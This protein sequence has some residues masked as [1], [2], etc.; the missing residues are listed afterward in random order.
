M[1]EAFRK[2][3]DNSGSK[4]NL[5]IAGS[6]DYKYYDRQILNKIDDLSLEDNVVLLGSVSKEELRY[7][8]S[9]CELLIFPSPFENFAY[10]LVEAMKCGAPIVCSNTTAMPETCNNAALYF[11]PYDI[12]DMAM[13]M[14]KVLQ[15]EALRI[16]MIK[17]SLARANELPDYGEV[18]I[19]TLKIIESQNN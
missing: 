3:I 10:T 5:L 18:T 17:K 2:S 19:E 13:N 14:S 15:D 16:S 12:N 11:D 9:N 6:R 1:I 4:L 8:Y 7:L